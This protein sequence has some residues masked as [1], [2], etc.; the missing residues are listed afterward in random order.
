MSDLPP[1]PEALE[2]LSWI[3]TFFDAL[4]YLGALMFLSITIGPFITRHLRAADLPH[5]MPALVGAIDLLIAFFR[6]LMYI[7]L[8]GFLL[9]FFIADFSDLLALDQLFT[10]TFIEVWIVFGVVW[11]LTE[12]CRAVIYG[13]D[14]TARQ[15]LYRTLRGKTTK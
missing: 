15:D 3:T 13:F 11:L 5:T 9:L 4:M 10:L 1:L 12:A 7:S 14:I 8:V 6:A 2:G